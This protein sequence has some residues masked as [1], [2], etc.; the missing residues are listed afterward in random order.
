MKAILDF[1]KTMSKENIQIMHCLEVLKHMNK[2]GRNVTLK[3][4]SKELHYASPNSFRPML[5]K[6][7]EKVDVL[8]INK[9]SRPYT[10]EVIDTTPKDF[11]IDWNKQFNEEGNGGYFCPFMKACMYCHYFFYALPY[12]RKCRLPKELY[13]KNTLK[14]MI[15]VKQVSK[16]EKI[17]IENEKLPNEW[18]LLQ[19]ETVF[20]LFA[21]AEREKQLLKELI[22]II[23]V[24]IY[25]ENDKIKL[26]EKVLE[27]LMKN[28]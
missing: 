9:Y 27:I 17:E 18:D 25:N 8:K 7:I 16:L 13:N 19:K 11:P 26:S 3:R 10:Y 20:D 5:K 23:E 4:W 22:Y 15:K 12:N 24:Y 2:Y 6:I 21:L 28:K 1:M 14:R